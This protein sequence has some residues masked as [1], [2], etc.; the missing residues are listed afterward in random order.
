MVKYFLLKLSK[1][2]PFH[3]L[4]EEWLVDNFFRTLTVVLCSTSNSYFKQFSFPVNEM[5][6]EEVAKSNDLLTPAM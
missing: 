3:S 2:M 6:L 5:F 4:L 1:V